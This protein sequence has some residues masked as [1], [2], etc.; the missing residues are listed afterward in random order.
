MAPGTG[1]DQR[2]ERLAG[3]CRARVRPGEHRAEPG[4]DGAHKSL[5]LLVVDQHRD[6]LADAHVA[7]LW[8]GEIGVEQQH[9][10]AELRGRERDVEKTTVVAAQDPDADPLGDAAVTKLAGER[11]RPRVHLRERERAE[12]VD[13][14]GALAVSNRCDR[15][16]GAELPEIVEGPERVERLAR[17][18]AADHAGTDHLSE[19]P[20][21]YGAS[22]T[23]PVCDRQRFRGSVLRLLATEH[24]HKSSWPCEIAADGDP[25]ASCART[26]IV[27]RA[28]RS[29][30]V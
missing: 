25:N 5:E 3:D 26:V 10:G 6:L 17:R 1:G 29:S 2:L 30:R 7:Q 15:R 22:A 13:Q 9:A 11:V 19:R 18:A 12:L 14:P 16:R 20:A 23:E 4:L 8:S 28:L 21:L 27:V 24:P